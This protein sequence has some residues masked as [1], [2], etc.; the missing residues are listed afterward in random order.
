MSE[1]GDLPAQH[2]PRSSLRST[3]L[4]AIVGLALSA[5]LIRT[6]LTTM[7]VDL[8]AEFR[9]SDRMLLATA[10]VVYVLGYVPCVA[11]WRPRRFAAGRRRSLDALA[12]AHVDTN[13]PVRVR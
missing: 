4:R 11:R 6:L 8:A 7:G 3:L 10:M 5:W 12:H 9:E 1:N 2:R 13:R